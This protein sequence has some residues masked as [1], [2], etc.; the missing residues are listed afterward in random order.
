LGLGLVDLGNVGL[1]LVIGG[2]L[3]LRMGCFP[4]IGM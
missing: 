4:L 2:K 1:E 3:L